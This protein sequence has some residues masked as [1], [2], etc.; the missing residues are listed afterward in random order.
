MVLPEGSTMR[1]VVLLIVGPGGVTTTTFVVGVWMLDVLVFSPTLFMRS[2]IRETS[3]LVEL[4]VVDVEVVDDEV[5]GVIVV[6]KVVVSIS[7][8]CGAM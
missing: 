8:A 6:L 3:M 5:L 7:E 2:A 1:T 4:L